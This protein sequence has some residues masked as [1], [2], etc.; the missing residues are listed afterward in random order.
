MIRIY[1]DAE[2]LSFAAA[3]LFTAEARQAVQARGRFTVVLAGGSTPRRTYEILAQDPFRELVPWEKTHIFW[4]DE[5]CVPGDDPRNNALM[6]RQELLDHVPIPPGQVHPMLCERSPQQAAVTYE[7]LLRVFFPD[8]QPRFDLVL[9]G[10]GENGHTASLFPGTAVL[11]E[12]QRWVAEVSVA[13]EEIHRLTLTA[14]A[15]NQA[16][17]VVFLVS[18]TS[19]APMLR[20]VLKE[21]Q[22]SH[23]IPA[24][25]IKPVDGGLLWLVDRD[26]ACQLRQRKEY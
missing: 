24:R 19:K 6:A 7:T 15:I 17:L 26:A 25:L 18:G 13:E 20:N 12:Q 16:A 14:A 21:A 23:R 1:P 3:E 11:D 4:G 9:L 10:L 2:A 8:G 5:R 22:N